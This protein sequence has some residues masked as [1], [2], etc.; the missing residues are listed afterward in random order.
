MNVVTAA[1][2]I[3][4][5]ALFLTM[6][7]ITGTASTRRTAAG[8]GSAPPSPGRGAALMS[9]V[10]GSVRLHIRPLSFDYSI[11]FDFI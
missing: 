8:D 1:A 6:R 3:V 4:I 9:S 2:T 11:P 10:R 7:A 5:G